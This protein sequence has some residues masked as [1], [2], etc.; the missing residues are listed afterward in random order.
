M[1]RRSFLQATSCALPLWLTGQTALGSNLLNATNGEMLVHTRVPLNSEPPLD[2]LV[3][4]F[5]TPNDWFYVRSHA[6]VPNIDADTFR[7]SVEGLV[8]RP[9]Q[10]SLRQLQ[11]D[12]QV[13]TVVATLTCAGNRRSEHSLTKP[14]DGVPWQAGAIGNA[15]WTGVPLGEVLARAGV[16]PQARHVWFEG[17]D[18][19]QRESEVIPFGA[20]I[21]LSKSMAKHGPL[22]GALLAYQM[23]GEPLPPDH[24]FPLRT[25]V[26]GYIGARSV[27]WLGRIIVSDRPSTNYYVSKAYK[28]V[29]DGTDQQ[30]KDAPPLEHFALNCVTCVP[31]SD[32]RPG[33][34]RM[35]VRGYS[36]AEGHEQRTIAKVELSTDEGRHWMP[37]RLTTKA[38]PFCWRLWEADVPITGETTSLIVRATDSAGNVQPQSTAWNLKGYMYNAW[39]KTAIRL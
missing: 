33:P 17:L 22:P 36:L 5:I 34:G 28:L 39:H 1:H 8:D 26:P 2:K 35:T 18:Q 13:Q 11:D 9:L 29:T 30:W 24:G 27:K 38:A 16:Q 20:S 6:P 4:S 14:V 15:S 10:L 23:N 19:I 12:F 3:E 37:A 25:V 31:G 7:L 32:D 21:P